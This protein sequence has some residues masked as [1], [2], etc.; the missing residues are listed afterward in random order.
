[1][2]I[3]MNVASNQKFTISHLINYMIK[4]KLI[5]RMNFMLCMLM[6]Q[7]KQD[8]AELIDILG[9]NVELNRIYL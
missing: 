8:F 9:V 5:R 6:K 1:M 7:L 3:V 4:R 2:S